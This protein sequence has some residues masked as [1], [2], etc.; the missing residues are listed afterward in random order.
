MGAC[1]QARYGESRKWLG[2]I[3]KMLFVHELP[4]A[5]LEK[6]EIR[7]TRFSSS[8]PDFDGLVQS[9]KVVLDALKKLKVIKDDRMDVIGVPTYKWERVKPKQGYITIY[10]E[11]EQHD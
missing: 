11:G 5:P 10:V 1:W 6:A 3:G 9:F 8:P 7:L 2:L 4:K